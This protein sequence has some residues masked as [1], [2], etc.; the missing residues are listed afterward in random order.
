MPRSLPRRRTRV[1]A[2]FNVRVLVQRV[3][4]A[5]V[6]VDGVV[7]GQINPESQGLVALV[8]VTH[9]DDGRLARQMAE[10]LW[11]LRILDDEA[12]AAD[13]SMPLSGAYEPS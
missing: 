3:S 13:I 11:R 2:S 12:S 4:T 6:V 7:V 9:A 1:A 5:R 10:K 8:G